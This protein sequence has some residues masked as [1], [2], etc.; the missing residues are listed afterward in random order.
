MPIEKLTHPRH[1]VDLGRRVR[2]RNTVAA[3]GFFVAPVRGDAVFG[4]AVHLAG[5]DL[6]FQRL[7]LGPDDRGVQG[8]VHPE[9]GLG[10]VIL[11]PARH[12]LPQGVHDAHG[13][14][15]VPDLVALDPHPDQ[16]VD[17]VEVAA[18]D[19]HLLI[20]RPVVLRSA[21][22]RG[23]DL[24]TAQCGADIRPHPGQI[25]IAGR[26]PVGYQTHDLL[27]TLGMQDCER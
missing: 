20:N 24:H 2:V 15:A 13:G 14:V 10:D 8:L 11:E 7:A 18:L 26:R 16:V 23:S 25:G 1:I 22:D 6:N 17:I 19:D 4:G 3:L 27:V 9:P 5:A 12:R 21:L